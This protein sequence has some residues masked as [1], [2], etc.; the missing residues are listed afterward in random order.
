MLQTKSRKKSS[1][2]NLCF[3]IFTVTDIN[4]R[5]IIVRSEDFNLELLLEILQ[6]SG[7]SISVNGNF[8]M[9]A[10]SRLPT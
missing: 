5:L 9:G 10:F 4:K 7:A 6:N 3:P 2:S 8:S 1:R